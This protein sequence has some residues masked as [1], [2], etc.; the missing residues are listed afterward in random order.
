MNPQEANEPVERAL[1]ADSIPQRERYLTLGA[2]LVVTLLS[3]LDQTI[4]S[5]ALPRIIDSLQGIEMYAWVGSAYMLTSTVMIP[6]YGKLSDL[7]GR[8]GILLFGQVVFLGG[9]MLCGLAG[10][11]GSL[12]ILGGG[13]SQ[14]VVFR[15]IQG[16][17]SAAL[18]STS[19][20][21][22]ADLFPPRERAKFMGLF[23]SVWGVAAIVGPAVGGFFTDFATVE[24]AGYEVA[25]WRWVF[26]V[27]LPL[28]LASMALI[29]FRM[30]R[31]PHNP[32]G[33]IDY[34]GAALVFATFIP[35]LLALSWAGHAYAW[36]SPVILSL[37]TLSILSLGLFIWVE[38]RTPHA[39]VPLDLFRI[40]A[41]SIT[42]CAAFLLG[43]AFFGVVMF[44]PLFMQA[45]QGV[46]ATES[47]FLMLPLM[48]GMLL[49]S[50][51]SGY[52]VSL[53]GRF[54]VLLIA[55][56][57]ALVIGVVLLS[58]IEPSTSAFDLGWRLALIGL[59]F[60]PSQ[61]IYGLVV[62]SSVDARHIGVA[63]SASQFF[64]QI[65]STIGMAVFGTLLTHHLTVELPKHV[66]NE[67]GISPPEIEL[68]EAQ[69]RAMNPGHV[70]DEVTAAVE[71]KYQNIARALRADKEAET[72]IA[73]D[74]FL[75]PLLRNRVLEFARETG[76]AEDA[77]TLL[78][79][80]RLELDALKAIEIERI[81]QGTKQ[82]FAAAIGA[83]LTAAIAIVIAGFLVTVAIPEIPLRGRDGVERRSSGQRDA[84]A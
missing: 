20:A 28:G 22:I 10:E 9:S 26:Y 30:P 62:Q 33:R 77:Q 84:N 66:P 7:Y 12:P 42:N 58:M 52:L 72:A 61:G 60:G 40:R 8:K 49:G 4:V 78:N 25:G 76:T 37:L 44:I 53:A 2:V 3:A 67:L 59:G 1:K 55:G 48:G 56:G 31:L 63:T 50:T 46:S 39:I 14:L 45:V 18:L 51:T 73:G 36:V 13:M 29:A 19:L 83:T 43:M 68:A 64:R 15:A 16:V 69:A 17:G 6:I 32:L 57:L 65:G 34:L 38:S 71:R 35:L 24:I 27:N 47:G 41:F 21:V 79:E 80:A 75:P 82:A 23:G 5:T 74:R 11:F 81:E 54:K 70:S